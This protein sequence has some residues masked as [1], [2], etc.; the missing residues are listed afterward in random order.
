MNRSRSYRMPV[1]RRS[2]SRRSGLTPTTSPRPPRSCARAS[3]RSPTTT[4]TPSPRS[5]TC[6]RRSPRVCS[7]TDDIDRAV[8]RLLELRIRTGEFDSDDDPYAGIGV[9]AIDLPASRVLAR[10]AGRALG[11]R[12]AQ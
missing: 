10:E 8:T 11:R 6:A 7:T 2:S 9:D 1:P 4:R 3:T 12:A 5:A